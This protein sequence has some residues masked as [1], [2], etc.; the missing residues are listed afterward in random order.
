MEEERKVLTHYEND[1]RELLK[2]KDKL[3]VYLE[4]AEAKLREIDVVGGVLAE[5]P[6]LIS[7]TR[8]YITKQYTNVPYMSIIA[9]VGALLYF[10]SP[11][12]LL[13]DLTPGYGKIDDLAV[14]GL[15]L[16]IIQADLNVYKEWKKENYQ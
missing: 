15:A 2:H 10:V 3:E 14:I 8:A 13:F 9:V 6:A 7:I 11:V 12:D 16:K 1:A 5:V 4:K